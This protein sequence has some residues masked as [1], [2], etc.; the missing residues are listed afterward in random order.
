MVAIFQDN[1]AL[2]ADVKERV[3]Q[4]YI[5]CIETHGRHVQ[6]LR[7]LETLVRAEGVFIRRCQDMVMSEV[8]VSSGLLKGSRSPKF[9][10]FQ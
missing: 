1:Q 8:R 9:F 10:V 3:V 2:C 5:H 7:F 6:Y 4:H